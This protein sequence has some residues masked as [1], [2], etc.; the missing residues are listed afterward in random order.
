MSSVSSFLLW[1][2]MLVTMGIWSCFFFGSLPQQYDDGSNHRDDHGV[3]MLAAKEMFRREYDT[4]QKRE[5][6]ETVFRANARQVQGQCNKCR[7]SRQGTKK[8]RGNDTG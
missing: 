6:K 4:L 5:K 3:T 2:R 7:G 8:H 1:A